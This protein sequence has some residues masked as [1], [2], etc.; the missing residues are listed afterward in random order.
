[1]SSRELEMLRKYSTNSMCTQFVCSVCCRSEV[2]LPAKCSCSFRS[3]CSFEPGYRFGTRSRCSHL[4]KTIAR[5]VAVRINEISLEHRSVEILIEQFS[6]MGEIC[7]VIC[8]STY[9]TFFSKH[10]L[11]NTLL[12]SRWAAPYTRHMVYTVKEPF[13][14]LSISSTSYCSTLQQVRLEEI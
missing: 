6:A 7:F 1:M 13:L 14:Y 9:R 12:W 5:K 10:F 8:A 4:K 3:N 2:C 11:R